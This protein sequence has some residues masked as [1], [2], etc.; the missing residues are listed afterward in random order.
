M[1]DPLLYEINTRCWLRD[2]AQAQGKPLTLAE[3]PDSEF[4]DWQRY[5]FTHIWLMGVWTGGRLALEQALHS[6]GL[7]RAYSEALPGWTESDVGPSPYAVADYQVSSALG[8]E[9]GLKVFRR[10]LHSYGMK[11]LLDFVPNHLGLD[12]PWVSDRPELFVQASEPQSDT[13]TADTAAGR[14]HLAYGRDPNCPPWTD[15]VQLDYRRAD[16]RAAMLGTLQQVANLC[17]GVRCDMAMLLLKDIFANTWKK[18]PARDEQTGAEFWAEAIKAI[19]RGRADFLFLAEVYW[20]LESRLQSLGFNF[21]YDKALYDTLVSWSPGAVQRHLIGMSPSCLASSAHFLE[22][23]DEP[24]IA[25]LLPQDEHRAAALVIL[26]LPGM[27]FIHE[28]QLSGR[29]R[30]LP[31]QLIHRSSETNDPAISSFYERMLQALRQSV[32]GSGHPE[33]LVPAQAWDS[34]PTAQH[35][36]LVQWTAGQAIDLVS[37]NLAPHPSQCYVPLKLPDTSGTAW[38]LDDLLGTESFVRPAEELRSRGLFLD[39]PAHSAQIFHFEPVAV[40][41]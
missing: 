15:T 16:T 11:L 22:N 28:G 34:N 13:F 3:V 10:K 6:S 24:R 37:V 38:R 39:V 30:R 8:D 32:V 25:A 7:A 23:H 27:R 12:H 19:R 1:P 14:R 33:L 21:T 18:Y 9:N 35:F 40:P 41:G 29:R 4:A 31:V 17:D 36:V 26:G 5:G 20:G 2:L